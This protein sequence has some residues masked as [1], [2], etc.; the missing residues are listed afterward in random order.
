MED[1][2][3]SF[4]DQLNLLLVGVVIGGII[5]ACFMSNYHIGKNKKAEKRIEAYERYYTCVETLLDSLD[6]T[7]DL[8][9]MDT[10]LETDY[11]VDYLDAKSKV[12]ELIAK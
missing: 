9:L 10:D 3:H 6:G 11:G 12:D 5:G 1:K 7:H 2:K 8:D 4:M